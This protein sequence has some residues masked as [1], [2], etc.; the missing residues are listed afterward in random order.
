M[1][2]VDAVRQTLATSKSLGFHAHTFYHDATRTDERA[3]FNDYRC[4]L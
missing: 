4:R 2:L 1:I 3:V